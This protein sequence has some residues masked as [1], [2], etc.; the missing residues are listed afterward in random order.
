MSYGFEEFEANQARLPRL[1]NSGEVDQTAL[2]LLPE[3]SKHELFPVFIKGDGNCFYNAISAYYTGNY[4]LALELRI[5]V[6]NEIIKNRLEYDIPLYSSYADTTYN[7]FEE[8][9]VIS[10]KSGTYSSLR[11]IAALS[12]VLGCNINSVYPEVISSCV[13][14]KDLNTV[15]TPKVNGSVAWYSREPHEHRK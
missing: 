4:D 13:N 12:N 9:V 5:K 3:E 8:D 1:F 15:F 6:V 10:I 11:H 14:R 2:M 7:S